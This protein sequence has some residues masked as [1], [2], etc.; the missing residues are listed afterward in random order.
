M[1]NLFLE[2]LI[3]MIGHSKANMRNLFYELTVMTNSDKEKALR[4]KDIQSAKLKRLRLE[5]PVSITVDGHKSCPELQHM[6]HDYKQE[7]FEFPCYA[8]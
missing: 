3:Q 1:F 5:T 6:R 7:R 8:I 4:I 2:K